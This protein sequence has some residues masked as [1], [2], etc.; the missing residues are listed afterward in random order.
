MTGP[1]HADIAAAL[2]YLKKVEDETL[3]RSELESVRALIGRL[4]PFARPEPEPKPEPAA[5]R[6]K[7]IEKRLPDWEAYGQEIRRLTEV[8][9]VWDF[10]P[11]TLFRQMADKL[12][13]D[14]MQR[15]MEK[16]QLDAY[17]K[18]ITGP[19]FI[20]RNRSEIIDF[21]ADGKAKS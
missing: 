7:A 16:A 13:R 1:A 5:P 11:N 9:P 14:V 2:G 21:D 19:V 20:E 10:R 4:E 3:S 18:A 8:K 15:N 6:E 17:I 12:A